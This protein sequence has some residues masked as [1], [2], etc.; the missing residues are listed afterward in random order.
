MSTRGQGHCSTFVQGH[1]D[2]YFQIS[3]AAKPLGPLK[4]NFMLLSWGTKV[5]S[6][7]VGC[8]AKMAGMPVYGHFFLFYFIFL[9]LWNQKPKM[10]TIG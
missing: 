6:V 3:S 10:M 1:T 4:P 2:L 8:K 7:D 5:C 9:F